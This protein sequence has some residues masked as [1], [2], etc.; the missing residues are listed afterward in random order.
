MTHEE[1]AAVPFGTLAALV[2]LRDFAKIKPGDRAMIIGASGGVG[3]YAV[4]IARHFGARTTGVCS[5]G[6][7][8]LV[9]SLGADRVID[10]ATED[11]TRPVERQD[12][13]LDTVG[14]TTFGAIRPAMSAHGVF[15][16]LNFGCRELFDSLIARFAGG[17]RIAI[18]INGD[19]REDL[20]VVA[21]LLE[22]GALKPVID[23]TYPLDRVA[24]AHRHV[25]GRHRK[26]AVVLSVA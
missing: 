22:T 6:N 17:P 15:V 16:P 20:E 26:G 18:G 8:T 14:A 21:E 3:C 1:A 7:A 5:A 2:F 11:F 19:R 4:Q 25:E 12:I 13:V 10:Y 23:R 24:E 9:R